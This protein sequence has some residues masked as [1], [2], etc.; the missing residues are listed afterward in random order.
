M[1]TNLT[2]CVTEG[3]KAVQQFCLNEGE[4]VSK[5]SDMGTCETE[6]MN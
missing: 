5:D 3:P 1:A 4:L 2:H 6:D